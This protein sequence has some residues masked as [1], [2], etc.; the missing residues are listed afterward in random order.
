MSCWKSVAT[1]LVV[2]AIMVT[3]CLIAR[4]KADGSCP[5]LKDAYTSAYDLAI[6]TNQPLVIQYGATWCDPCRE[7]ERLYGAELR[8]CGVYLHLDVERDRKLM[9]RHG[10]TPPT[11]LPAVAIYPRKDHAWCPPR[12]MIGLPRIGIYIGEQRRR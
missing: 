8:T 6:K 3:V 9:E 12:I 5:P 7:C 10:L 4:A 11:H 2:I 1:L